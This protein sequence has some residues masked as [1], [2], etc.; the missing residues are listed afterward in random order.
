MLKQQN[1][2]S[3]TGNTPLSESLPPHSLLSSPYQ[4]S[5]F[6]FP[7]NRINVGLNHTPRSHPQI[8]HPDHT[9]RSHTHFAGTHRKDSDDCPTP[10]KKPIRITTWFRVHNANAPNRLNGECHS[11]SQRKKGSN[12][13]CQL[14]P[15]HRAR[16]WDNEIQTN[17]ALL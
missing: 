10:Q 7:T 11:L 8:T 4:Q 1:G 16:R 9:P 2:G 3:T 6:V 5:S 12:R 14:L 13:H 15:M 17:V